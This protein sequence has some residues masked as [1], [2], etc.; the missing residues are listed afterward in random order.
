MV[1]QYTNLLTDLSAVKHILVGSGINVMLCHRFSCVS[2][3][4]GYV[5]NFV[6]SVALGMG[7]LIAIKSAID[8]EV[9]DKKYLT[10]HTA[11]M[12]EFCVA[13]LGIS[14]MAYI[15]TK[16]NKLLDVFIDKQSLEKKKSTNLNQR[17]GE[18]YDDR[19]K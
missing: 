9:L 7:S 16:L 15:A 13:T 12:F 6:S 5:I 4:W 11:F 2:S 10:E 1:N 8:L 14:T 18:Y 3:K 19:Y 17:E